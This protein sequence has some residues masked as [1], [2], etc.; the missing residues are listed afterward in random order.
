MRAF[1]SIPQ[2]VNQNVQIVQRIFN[3]EQHHM[4][5]DEKLLL[6]RFSLFLVDVTNLDAERLTLGT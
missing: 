1:T 5:T 4:E 3:I 6:L 2:I